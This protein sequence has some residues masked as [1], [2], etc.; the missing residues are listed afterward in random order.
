MNFK[1]WNGQSLKGDWLFTYKID[2]IQARKIKTFD[3]YKRPKNQIVSKNNNPLYNIPKTRKNFLIA[4]I[5]TGLWGRTWSIVSASK[6]KRRQIKEEEIYPLFPKIDKR[7]IIGKFSNPSAMLIKIAFEQ[8]IA[9]EY[10]GLV[11]RQGDTF[12]KV[13]TEY[14]DDVKVTGYV[15]GKGKF[16]GMLGKLI[17]DSGDC[18]IGFNNAQRTVYWRHR[19]SLIGKTVEI[20]SM[21]RTPK[22]KLRNPRFVRFRLD[23]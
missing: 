5:F 1:N 6:S 19:K 2:G 18:G 8:A 13:K 3:K 20:V 17:T 4:E 9:Q 15:E 23:K 22:G 10:E 21:E 12:I 16:K 11:L 14:S 7:L